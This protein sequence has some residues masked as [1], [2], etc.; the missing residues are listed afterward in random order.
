VQDPLKGR[1]QT[2]TVYTITGFGTA[3]AE[4]GSSV[5]APGK[6]ARVTNGKFAGGWAKCQTHGIGRDLK[7][8][9][10]DA[11][12]RSIANELRPKFDAVILVHS[13]TLGDGV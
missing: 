2:N 6:R 8:E 12:R 3:A 7:L 11:R 10:G 1:V 4:V 13:E 5:S 9:Y